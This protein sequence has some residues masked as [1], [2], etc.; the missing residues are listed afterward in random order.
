MSYKNGHAFNKT[1]YSLD[2]LNTPFYEAFSQD[3]NPFSE[4]A[5]ASQ[6]DLNFPDMPV[7]D[8]SCSCVKALIDGLDLSKSPGPDRISPKLLKLSP[9]EAS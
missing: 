3:N 5:N 7:I 8:I 2:T 4:T 1:D 6:S 9:E